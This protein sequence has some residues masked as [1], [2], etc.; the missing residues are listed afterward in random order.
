MTGDI[1]QRVRIYISEHD[2]WS[3]KPLYVA[4]MERLQMEGASGA[5]ALRGVVGFGPSQRTRAAGP[6]LNDHTPL[7]IE[8]ID[9]ADRVSRLLAL[10]NDM[11]PNA[12]ITVEAVQVYRAVMRSQGP[13]GA[14]RSVGD[15]MQT[16]PQVLPHTASLQQAISAMITHD[17]HTLPILD[18]QQNI[19]GVLTDDAINR[20]TRLPLPVRLLRLLG[21]EEINGILDNLAP[22]PLVEVM[23]SEPHTVYEGASLPQALVKMVEWDYEQIPVTNRAGTFAGLLDCNAVLSTVIEQTDASE[24]VRDA[25][26]PTP[27]RLIMQ[28]LVPRIDV[29]QPMDAALYHLLRSPNRYLV[30]V[31]DAGHVQGSLSDAGVLQCLG[32]DERLMWLDALQSSTRIELIA[33]PGAGR[34]IREVMDSSNALLAPTDSIID[35]ARR[36]LETGMERLPVVSDEGNLIGLLARSGLLR[37]LLQESQ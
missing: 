3:D 23:N 5:T 22:P 31:D 33:L 28:S 21:Q 13:F 8:W 9:R 15:I 17:Q 10:L 36:L 16:R 6:G 19:L 7:L 18:E 24:H 37:A 4:V 27:V 2:N 32:G 29:A 12:L 25:T 20:R 34:S 14:E 1:I 11:L 26:P 30:V 35:A